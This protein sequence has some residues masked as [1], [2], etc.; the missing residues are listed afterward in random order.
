M[1]LPCAAAGA[2]LSPRSVGL[3]V[4]ADYRF[5]QLDEVQTP[6]LLLNVDALERNLAKMADLARGGGKALR[7][8]SKTYK[9]PVI[10]KKQVALGAVEILS[11]S[12]RIRDGSSSR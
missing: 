8:H 9:S 11:A 1:P 6:A 7:P 12:A 10:A 5:V 2:C 3:N 4:A